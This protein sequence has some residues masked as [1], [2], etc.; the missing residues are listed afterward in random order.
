V[1]VRCSCS[2]V[3][4]RNHAAA[5]SDGDCHCV[6][7]YD[8]PPLDFRQVFPTVLQ[9]ATDGPASG[10]GCRGL[11]RPQGPRLQVVSVLLLL[12]MESSGRLFPSGRS[13]S[14]WIGFARICWTWCSCFSALGWPPVWPPK[15]PRP[16]GPGRC[17]PADPARA[18][19]SNAAAVLSPDRIRMWLSLQ[20]P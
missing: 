20:W 10:V 14:G 9:D 12:A 4:L 11:Q 8:Q 19:S 17:S 13:C 1:P 16:S 2:R 7:G 18:P 15:Q 5:V 3:W 6:G